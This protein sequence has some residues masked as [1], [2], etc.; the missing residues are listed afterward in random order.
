MTAALSH[1]ALPKALCSPPEASLASS[2]LRDFSGAH[3]TL[4]LDVPQDPG[5]ETGA[6]LFGSRREQR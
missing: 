2:A 6:I 4:H 1:Q 5:P 3:R